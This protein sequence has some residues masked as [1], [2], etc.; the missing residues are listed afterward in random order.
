MSCD[1]GGSGLWPLTLRAVLCY[2]VLLCSRVGRLDR[3][4]EFGLP[5]LEGRTHILRIHAKV[6]DDRDE[7]ISY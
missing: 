2:V 4:V 6:A 1:G 7:T 5:D 3:K